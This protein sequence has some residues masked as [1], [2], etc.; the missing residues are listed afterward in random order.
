HFT[1]A[2]QFALPCSIRPGF[3]G[4]QRHAGSVGGQY[5]FVRAILAYPRGGRRSAEV[6]GGK[7]ELRKTQRAHAKTRRRQEAKENISKG[8]P[9]L[10][11]EIPPSQ[12]LPGAECPEAP[13]HEC[14]SPAQPLTGGRKHS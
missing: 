5:G 2:G 13:P 8:R 14:F 11:P 12:A 3:T 4:H 10:K 6:R 7:P 9:K 1:G